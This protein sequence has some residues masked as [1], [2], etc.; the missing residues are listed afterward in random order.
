MLFKVPLG[1]SHELI[2]FYKQGKFT[3]VFKQTQA[4]TEQYPMVFIFWN[5]LGASATK[6]R[7]L[8]KAI[9]GYKNVFLLHSNHADASCNVGC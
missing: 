7:I 9:N 8:D 5:I 6:I 4:L 3:A 2:N 1:N